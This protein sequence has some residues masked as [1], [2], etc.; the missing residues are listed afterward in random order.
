MTKQ[1]ILEHFKDINA[2]YNECTR[3]DDLSR[4]LD[5]L[6][7]PCKDAISRQMAID[8][9]DAIIARDT[10]GNNDV[11]KAMT[12]WKSYVEG[13]PPVTAQPKMGRWI[14]VDKGLKVTSFKCSECGRT[15]RD[16]TGYDVAKDYPYCHCGAKMQEVEE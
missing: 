2:M 15:V 4:M 11:V 1:D 7:E 12:A 8:G 16:D 6:Q 14:I 13:L 5:E 3:Y 9:A 10:S